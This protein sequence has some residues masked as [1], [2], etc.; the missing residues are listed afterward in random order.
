MS[1]SRLLLSTGV[2][3]PF[4]PE[5]DFTGDESQGGDTPAVVL[6]LAGGGACAF[7]APEGSEDL[8]TAVANR[9]ADVRER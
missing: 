6:L 2:L 8:S 1:F 4:D 5:A 3:V 9:C 7:T